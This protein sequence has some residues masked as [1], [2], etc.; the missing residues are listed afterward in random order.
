M[1][2]FVT[3][4]VTTVKLYTTGLQWQRKVAVGP[5]NFLPSTNNSDSVVNIL[6]SSEKIEVISEDD[7]GHNPQASV[8]AHTQQTNNSADT[9]HSLGGQQTHHLVEVEIH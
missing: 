5:I 3:N 8:T 9:Y 4:N 2:L 6:E 7:M 1:K